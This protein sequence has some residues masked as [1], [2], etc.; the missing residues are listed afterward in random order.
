LKSREAEWTQY[1]GLEKF[2]EDAF[3]Q[4]EHGVRERRN[5]PDVLAAESAALTAFLGEYNEMIKEIEDLLAGAITQ[6]PGEAE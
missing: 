6:P 2:F 4:I 5:E 1:R 3:G